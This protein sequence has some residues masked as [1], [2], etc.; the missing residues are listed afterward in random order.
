VPRWSY[1]LIGIFAWGVLRWLTPFV[2]VPISLLPLAWLVALAVSVVLT[3]WLLAETGRAWSIRGALIL[4]LV[5]L[6]VRVA[7][8][9]LS[10]PEAVIWR[11]ALFALADTFLLATALLWG[12]AL[13]VLVREVNLVLPV[14][15]VLTVVDIWAVWLG[16]SVAQIVQKAQQGV[17]I[18]Q[19]I[20]EAATVKVPVVV[21]TQHVRIGVPVIGIGDFFFGA[22]LF[23]LLWRFGLNVGAAFS[24]S[25]VFVALGVMMAQLPF[26][27][28]GVPGL[29]FLALAVLLPNWRAFR[30]TP[31]EKRAL[32]IGGI[33]LLALLTLFSLLL[34]TVGR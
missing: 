3:V 5:T 31:E 16:G 29:P 23:A 26:M 20:V 6:A 27:P 11:G 13:S 10:L 18:A 24:F 28:V 4:G 33:F 15:V 21:G 30:F 1:W 17:P 19:K 22:F 8:G 12:C 7:L 34:R 2:P 9:A 32:V 25:V 14:A